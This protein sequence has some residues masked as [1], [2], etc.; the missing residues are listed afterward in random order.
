MDKEL[1][2]ILEVYKKRQLL[3]DAR[4]SFFE[5]ENVAHFCRLYE[6]YR[7][8]LRLLRKAD[9]R[10]LSGKLILDV[11]SGDGHMLR[12]FLQWGAEPT[13]L[14]GIDL[15]PEVVQKGRALNQGID[16]RL[17]S[18]TN[19]PW[20]DNSFDIVCQHTVFSS[21]LDIAMK[22]RVASE[23]SRV[24]RPAGLILWYDFIYNNPYNPDVRGIKAREIELLFP[25]FQ[26]KLQRITL[27]P[28]IG[29][30]IPEPLL[31]YAYPLLS[32]I[33]ILRTHYLGLFRKQ[34]VIQ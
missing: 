28:F 13:C 14:A 26:I 32:I 12:Q 25:H 27:A 33:P 22:R 8:T 30:A 16:I 6:R 24:L 7:E 18:A 5:Y 21:I 20:P 4:K 3:D 17:G 11:G 29:R 23:M 9:C 31:A 15:I 34:S 10:S 1:S 2:R 19:L